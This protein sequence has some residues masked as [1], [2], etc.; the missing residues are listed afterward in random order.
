[1]TETAQAEVCSQFSET[2]AIDKTEEYLE[3][4]RQLWLTSENNPVP[5]PAA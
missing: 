3:T 4:S 2:N 5:G 1:M